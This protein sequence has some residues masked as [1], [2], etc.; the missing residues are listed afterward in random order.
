[1]MVVW[2]G[3]FIVVKEATAHMPP[4]GF[5]FLRYGLASFSLLAILRWYEG[6]IA[7]PRPDTLRI[8]ALGAVGYGAYQI[9]W[10]IGLQSIPAGDSALILAAT[11]VFTAVLAVAAGA[12]T[13]NPMKFAGAVLSFVGVV[14][15]IAA[16]IGI[17]MSGSLLG[18]ALTLL[19]ALCWATYTS[20]AAPVLRHH[21][22]LVL[23]T[24]AT[25]AGTVVMAPIGISQLLA[26]GAF[27]PEQTER[28][29]PIVLAVA[30]S[31]L[32]AAA[33][34]NIVVFNGVRLLGPTR[35]TTLQSL[36]PAMAVVLA[37]IF[38]NEPIGPVQVVGGGIIIL[39][40]ALTRRAYG[41]PRAVRR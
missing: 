18:S 5:T 22:P 23:T 37:A 28:L 26:P 10:T 33:I 29:L 15:V 35:I 38:L 16:G 31:G 19:A 4:V 25:I 41:L 27:G 36:V 20:F 3:N 13:L 40:V 14:L 8:F 17:S 11:P 21:S 9:L 24:W 6:S 30:Y 39:G 32:L 7:L 1:M 2:A 12:D 34:A